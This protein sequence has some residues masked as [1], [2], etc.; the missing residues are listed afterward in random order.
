MENAN[1]AENNS[2]PIQNVPIPEEIPQTTTPE[3]AP[4][5]PPVQTIEPPKDNKF[6]KILPVILIFVVILIAG[7]VVFKLFTGSKVEKNTNVASPSPMES[8][9]TSDIDHSTVYFKQDEG[10]IS[11]YNIDTKAI[12]K[13]ADGEAFAVTNDGT[14]MAYTVGYDTAKSMTITIKNLTTGKET[15]FDAKR[16]LI[17]EL[18]WSTN[19]KYL[20]SDSGTGPDGEMIVYD[21]SGNHLATFGT[22]NL[23]WAENDNLL[24][25]S[26]NEKVDP[27]RP[28]GSG[29]GTGVSVIN[30]ST[31]NNQKILSPDGLTDYGVVDTEN[32]LIYISKR[33][34]AKPEDWSSEQSVTTTYLTIDPK[35][36]SADPVA[37]ATP[38]KVT[39]EDSLKQK[40][41]DSGVLNLNSIE[42]YNWWATAFIG[43]ANWA[44]VGVYPGSNVYTT[45]LYLVNLNNPSES[46]VHIGKGASEVWR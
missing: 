29:Y 15:S 32:N 44:I 18:S 2:Q 25:Y 26:Q 39:S 33:S 14:Q 8:F 19:G 10:T 20:V 27:E 4:T 40:L 36:I 12:E 23:V 24:F 45:E 17:R 13:V 41:L 42:K 46:L 43:D 7:F 3:Q 6:K 5:I 31:G 16:S 1:P 28:W 22:S 38:E 11:K 21:L 35:N 30:L 34:V 37:A 9:S